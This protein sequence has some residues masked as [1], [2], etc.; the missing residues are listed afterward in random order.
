MSDGRRS[1]LWGRM[2]HRAIPRGVEPTVLLRLRPHL[3][4]AGV[5][6]RGTLSAAFAH[7]L[8]ARTKAKAGWK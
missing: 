7:P 3:C 8:A 6:V 1:G 5:R 2:S 4:W